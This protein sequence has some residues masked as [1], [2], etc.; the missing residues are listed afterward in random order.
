[1]LL[2]RKFHARLAP[3]PVGQVRDATREDRSRN[4]LSYLGKIIAIQ[5][6][7]LNMLGIS[8][9]LKNV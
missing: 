4:R 6:L 8:H 5:E 1:M 9:K 7:R 2:P 3:Q